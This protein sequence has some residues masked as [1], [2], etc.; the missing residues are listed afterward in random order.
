MSPLILTKASNW[1]IPKLKAVQRTYKIHSDVL[2]P[3]PLKGSWKGRSITLQVYSSPVRYVLNPAASL[4]A[5]LQKM[6][7]I[8]TKELSSGSSLHQHRSFLGP[9]PAI[10]TPSPKPYNPTKPHW[11]DT[12][13][14]PYTY[15]KP[16][17]HHMQALR[18]VVVNPIARSEL[19]LSNPLQYCLG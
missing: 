9:C 19:W 12:H 7:L 16:H 11:A 3:C 1:V 10:R 18:Y 17:W 8:S 2:L 6:L 14:E 5:W 15:F 4:E 13:L